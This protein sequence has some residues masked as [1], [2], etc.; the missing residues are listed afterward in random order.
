MVRP[1]CVDI[2]QVARKRGERPELLKWPACGEGSCSPVSDTALSNIW[3]PHEE[4]AV[5]A[6]ISLQ[7]AKIPGWSWASS[8]P[9]RTLASQ[10]RALSRC[11]SPF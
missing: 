5:Q 4:K 10:E 11:S 1:P 9:S 6:R 7:E 8:W 2:P 3:A